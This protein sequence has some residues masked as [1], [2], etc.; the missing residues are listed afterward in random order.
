MLCNGYDEV[1]QL[2]HGELV[3]LVDARGAT[4]RVTKGTIWLTQQDDTQD[5]VLR[6]GDV[7]TI[8]R[9]GLTILEA[10]SDAL[11]CVLGTAVE[12]ARVARAGLRERL[13]SW[14][15]SKWATPGPHRTTPYY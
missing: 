14:L 10:Q 6:P 11:V 1:L 12:R 15:R 3:E 4:V 5:V 13:N 9:Q 7:W 8:E 2:A